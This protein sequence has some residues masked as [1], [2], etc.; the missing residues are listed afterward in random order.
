MLN[1]VLI[2][3]LCLFTFSSGYSQNS[4]IRIA[5]ALDLKKITNANVGDIII[6]GPTRID[7]N[8]KIISIDEYFEKKLLPG[9]KILIAGGDYDAIWIEC[10]ASGTK[11]KPII[12]TN[13]NGQV[14]AKQ[15]KIAGNYWLKSNTNDTL[16]GF[17]H[18]SRHLIRFDTKLLQNS[19]KQINTIIKKTKNY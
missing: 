5:S 3:L 7:N 2:L 1:P 8:K 18:H 14:K 10:I 17:Y 16:K 12:I 13:Y 6:S 15:I 11:N 19:R 4:S 9:Q